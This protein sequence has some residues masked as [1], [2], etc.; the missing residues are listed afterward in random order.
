M[1]LSGNKN[2]GL[3]TST[4]PAIR[5]APRIIEN[6]LF[7]LRNISFSSIIYINT[8]LGCYL[9][10]VSLPAMAFITVILSLINI[11]A[12]TMVNKGAVKINVMASDTGINFTHANDVSMVRLPN[13]P[14][15]HSIILWYIDVGQNVS[16]ISKIFYTIAYVPKRREVTFLSKG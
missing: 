14:S 8:Y 4:M 11:A 16:P 9:T 10:L 6:Y 3:V 2:D 12:I 1:I 15:T 5:I 7:N 13:N